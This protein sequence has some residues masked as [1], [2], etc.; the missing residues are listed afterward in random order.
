MHKPNDV[1]HLH[2]IFNVIVEKASK[3]EDKQEAISVDTTSILYKG[4]SKK[5]TVCPPHSMSV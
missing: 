1:G 3:R 5:Q 4:V 2:S